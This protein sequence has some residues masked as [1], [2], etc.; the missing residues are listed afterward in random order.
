MADGS[1]TVLVLMGGESSEHDIS[2]RSGAAVAANLAAAGWDPVPVVIGRDGRFAFPPAGAPDA[3]ADPVDLGVAVARMQALAPAC[4]FPALHGLYGEDGRIQALCD[5]MHV[6]Y[7]GADVIGSAVSMDKWLA[8]AAY[9]AHGIPTADAVLLDADALALPGWR[10]GVLARPGL[11]CVVKAPRQGSSVGVRI[12]RDAAALAEAAAQAA[13]LGPRVMFEAFHKGRELSVPVLEDPETGVP[14]ALP[15]IEIVVKTREF[16]DYDAKYDAQATDEICPAPIPADLAARVAG[17]AVAAHRALMLSGFSR[18]DFIA[19]PDGTVVTLETNTIP[20]LTGQSLF[21][22]AAAVAGI[23]FP[24]LL[25]TLV[26]R[27]IRV[28]RRG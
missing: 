11:P 1:R 5:L 10:D 3:P 18:T 12:V 24:A 25:D 9:H 13:A 8:K 21:P 26:R 2:L 6:P 16:F 22:K 27:A 17:L 4:A 23:P 20:G 14:R 19:S 15:A 28:G 7:V